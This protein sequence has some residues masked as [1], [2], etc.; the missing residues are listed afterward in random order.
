[1]ETTTP[2]P[3]PQAPR[4]G[5][6]SRNWK[7]FLPTGCCL[8]SLIG[9]VLAIAVFGVGIFG[10][11][12]GISKVLKSSEPYQ[13]ALA[14]AKANENVV[15]ALGTPIEE[16]FPMGSVNTNNDG[17]DADLSIPVSG[18]KGK[19]TIYVVGKRAGRTWTYSKMSVA[20]TGSGE[21]IDLSP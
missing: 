1:M 2:P 16:G 18:P 19:G 17:G 3:A 15:A 7:W 10:L 12:S 8:G 5:W 21:T 20:I 6:W 4:P 14:R 11:I 9:I 13:T